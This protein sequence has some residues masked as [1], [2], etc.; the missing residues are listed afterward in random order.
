MQST[1][2]VPTL[3]LA[4]ITN[5]A[6]HLDTAIGSVAPFVDEIVIVDNG[7]DKRVKKVATRFEAKYIK[8]SRKD[9]PEYFLEYPTDNFEP[10]FT[11]LRRR[12]FEE[13]TKDWILWL[14]TDD[15]F[16]NAQEIKPTLIEVDA[17][18][19]DVIVLQYN[20]QVDDMGNVLKVHNKERILRRG[21]WQWERDPDWAVHENLYGVEEENPPGVLIY[22][23]KVEHKKEFKEFS[24][25]NMRNYNI[26]MAMLKKEKFQKDPRV[27]YLIGRELIS[28]RQ[29]D[30]VIDIFNRY[31]GME[32]AAHDALDACLRCAEILEATGNFTAALAYI[33]KGISI[34]PDHPIGYLFAARYLNY[35]G[36]AEEAIDMLDVG[37]KKT[38]NPLDT[39]TQEPL[40]MQWV[41]Y[42]GYAD[43]YM[44]LKQYGK[45]IEVIDN[46]IHRFDKEWKKQL[47][48]IRKAADEKI[49][50]DEVMNAM[51]IFIDN[52]TGH[53][54]SEGKTPHIEDYSSIFEQFDKSLL[55]SPIYFNLRK[56]TGDYRVHGD[57]EITIVHMNNFEDWD[58]DTIY[59]NG[60]GGSETACVELSTWWQE[61]GYKV[62]VYASPKVDG[63][64]F[65]GVT[66]RRFENVNL[67]DDFNIFIS[68]RNA[69]IFTDFEIH[70]RKKFVWLQDIMYPEQ[71]TPQ[72]YDKIDKI[73]VLSNYHRET[74]PDVP[75]G[76]FYYTTNG[77]NIRLIEEVEKEDI[78]RVPNKCIYI[79][80]A[81]RGLQ[82]LVGM[83]GGIKKEI[84]DADL[85]WAYGWNSWNAFRKE[86]DAEKFK[87][88]MIDGMA[89][90][91]IHELGRISKKDLYRLIRSATYHLYPLIGPAETSCIAVM[92]TQALGAIPITTGITAL[93]ETQQYG[94]KVP[95]EV[96][97]TAVVRTMKNRYEDNE[98]YRAKMM[99]W[100]RETY[101]WEKVADRWIKD[102]FTK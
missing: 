54:V 82:P 41:A 45:A 3:S 70:A 10:N 33:M 48:E 61:K 68:L 102:L 46:N 11:M 91:G 97:P 65:K 9:N 72:L 36:K 2:R 93:E 78:Q 35:Q 7:T 29:Y 21:V 92:E 67:A 69:L 63:T 64:V 80:S 99:K 62:T 17:A 74:A 79:S 5:T 22:E 100:A 86:G 94:I 76:K 89:K 32:Y 19:K 49:R 71:Y 44:Q 1:P 31:L 12:S 52:K 59:N 13:C 39:L 51:Q 20:Y 26:L 81:D 96:Y 38:I 85:S 24:K 58:P 57:N 77:I 28:L 15:V 98:Q 90:N 8:I 73:I 101:D 60:G 47:E 42:K 6:E 95:L 75:E 50:L 55:L 4:M 16:I 84:P 25:S 27:W 43:A 53:L 56:Q 88:D 18:K 83:W 34:R 23:M 66:W 40:T 14:D 87:Q 30:K 37:M